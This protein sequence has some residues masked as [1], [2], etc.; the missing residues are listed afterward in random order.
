MRLENIAGQGGCFSGPATKAGGVAGLPGVQ[1]PIIFS[2]QEGG[3]PSLW[4]CRFS[5]LIPAGGQVLDLAC[6][7]GRHAKWL[8]TQGWQVE[9]VDRDSS[10]LAEIGGI[11]NIV[12]RQA[13]LE[14]G[15]WPYGGRRFHGVVVSRYLHRPLLPLLVDALHDGGVLMYEIFM[16]GQERLGRPHNPDFLLRRNELL[17]AFDGRLDLVA[18]EQGE[19]RFP[20]PAIVQRICAVKGVAGLLPEITVEQLAN[21]DQGL[22]PCAN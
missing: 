9:A 7:R 19:V 16:L 13:D 17:E 5:S 14:S 1:S 15:V 21:A 3:N 12:T 4:V 6:G 18:F 22:A 11:Q 8:A 10:A 2:N 20:C